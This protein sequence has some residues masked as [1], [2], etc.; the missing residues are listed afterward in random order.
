MHYLDDGT[1]KQERLL[2]LRT[3]CGDNEL[4][5]P[6]GQLDTPIARATTTEKFWLRMLFHVAVSLFVFVLVFVLAD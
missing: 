4:V 2:V 1:R 6:I 3:L 5:C